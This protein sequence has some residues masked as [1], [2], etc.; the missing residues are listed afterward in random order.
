MRR[1]GRFMNLLCASRAPSPRCCEHGVE[2]K[3]VTLD[4]GRTWHWAPPLARCEACRRKSD[5]E[6]AVCYVLSLIGDGRT[7]A[8][9][10]ENVLRDLG[11]SPEDPPEVDEIDRRFLKAYPLGYF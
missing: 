1:R 3:W 11:F 4:W 9:E 8:G 5:W 10:A 2:G 6:T 7:W